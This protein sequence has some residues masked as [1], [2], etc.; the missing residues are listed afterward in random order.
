MS[1]GG[2]AD[3]I[4]ALHA[5]DGNNN[6]LMCGDGGNDVGALKAA[7]VGVAL[8]AGH[9]NTNTSND[10]GLEV[11]TFDSP[12]SPAAGA[13]GDGG[14]SVGPA[15]T[16]TQAMAAEDLLNAHD[17]S[18]QRRKAEAEKLRKLHMKG[19]QVGQLSHCHSY[20]YYYYYN[21]HHHV[22]RAF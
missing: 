7:A 9:A 22:S 13:A 17:K 6:V 21:H 8:L 11:P 19:Y 5:V 1:P 12:A 14:K 3:V 20:Y 18:I 4:R 10:T 15:T 16:T 2:K